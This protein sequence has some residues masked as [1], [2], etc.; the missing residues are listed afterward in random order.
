M[1]LYHND[2][3]DGRAASLRCNCK[4]N[5]AVDFLEVV[6]EAKGASAI[7][8]ESVACFVLIWARVQVK[9]NARN[10]VVMPM[11]SDMVGDDVVLLRGT[12]V[13]GT[14]GIYKKSYLV[15]I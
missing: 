15:Y 13:N 7:S 14:Y 4:N 8:E 12:I 2:Y 10:E 9:M 1:L 6:E 3:Y 5:G 11:W